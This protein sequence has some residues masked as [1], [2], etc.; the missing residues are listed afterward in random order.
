[1]KRNTAPLEIA[2]EPKQEKTEQLAISLPVSV[3]AKFKEIRD[4]AEPYCDFIATYQKAL[5]TWLDGMEAWVEKKQ[6]EVLHST[7]GHANGAAT[8]INR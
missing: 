6:Q 8:S 5:K 3:V 7:N 2:P 1:M 4:K